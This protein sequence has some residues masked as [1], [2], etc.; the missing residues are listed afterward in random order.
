MFTTFKKISF[1]RVLPRLILLLLAA[2][3]LLAVTG[4]GIFRI[5]AG[6]TDLD[7]LSE[8]ELLGAYVTFDCSRSVTSFA[9]LSTNGTTHEQFYMVSY[10]DGKYIALAA[11]KQ[12]FNVLEQAS[13]QSQKYYLGD[14]ETLN[15]LGPISGYV[16]ELDKDLEEYFV[17]ALENTG[18]HADDSD[19]SQ[20]IIPV[21][22]NAGKVN[23]CPTALIYIF[24]VLAILLLAAVVVQILHV[25]SG[26]Y[27]LKARRAALANSTEEELEKD[28]AD[29]VAFENAWVGKLYTWHFVGPKT[30][31]EKTSDIIWAFNRLDARFLGSHRY[32]LSIYMSDRRNDEIQTATEGER[33][34]I[35]EAIASM[36]YPFVHGYSQE[37]AH[38]FARELPAFKALAKR[39]AAARK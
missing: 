34:R 3:L 4:L 22:V 16:T 18:I 29:A 31:V 15:S 23:W 30:K 20:R 14:Q 33:D 39:E 35:A 11:K 19:V 7:S 13:D 5:F 6:P 9:S 10:G 26:G 2:V 27:Q 12:Y 32:S 38:M 21:M 36:G 24:T 8:D 17:T 25:C 37:R 28:F 1:R